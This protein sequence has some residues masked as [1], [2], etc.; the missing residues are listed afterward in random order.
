MRSSRPLA[1]P[2]NSKYVIGLQINQ[3]NCCPRTFS[4]A[5]R[6]KGNVLNVT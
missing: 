5:L 6:V 3:T 2:T 4:K 1:G